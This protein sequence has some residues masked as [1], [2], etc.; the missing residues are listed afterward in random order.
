MSEQILTTL[1]RKIE[2]ISVYGEV[3][4]ETK[5]NI[6]KEELQ[7]YILNFIYHH[8]KYG[9]WIIDLLHNSSSFTSISGKI[10]VYEIQQF[11]TKPKTL[12]CLY[13]LDSGRV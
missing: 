13:W 2:D 7:F 12:S 1:K 4:A 6:L 11:K 10:E 8:P 3:D 9:K 5:R